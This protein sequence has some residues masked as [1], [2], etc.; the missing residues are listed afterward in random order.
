MR[1]PRPD[2]D[3]HT[4]GTKR[5]EEWAYEGRKEPGREGNTPHR[6]RLNRHQRRSSQT[7][8][9]ENAEPAASVGRNRETMGNVADNAG[10]S[11]P[12]ASFATQ[13]ATPLATPLAN[14]QRFVRKPRERT[15][16][17]EL[18]A[19][20]LAPAHSAPAGVGEA[21]GDLRL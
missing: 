14:L 15:E 16:V 9:S 6:P 18:C 13:P 20:P 2:I 4:P 17:C 7:N 3:A 19:A 10:R 1:N 11:S 5:G 8:R 21:H 12:A